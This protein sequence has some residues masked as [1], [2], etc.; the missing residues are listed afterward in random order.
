MRHAE[1]AL[2]ELE[3]KPDRVQLHHGELG[4]LI[5]ERMNEV[6]EPAKS[7]EDDDRKMKL[8]AIAHLARLALRG[9]GPGSLSRGHQG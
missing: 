4:R 9:S 3:A 2:P 7:G 1:T 5:V 6:S 8:V